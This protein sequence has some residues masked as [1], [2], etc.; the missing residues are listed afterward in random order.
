MRDVLP[1]PFYDN[2]LLFSVAIT[3]LLS[4]CLSLSHTNYARSLLILFVTHVLSLYGKEMI[5]YNLH[6]LV[7]LSDETNHFG[8]LDKVSS[9]PFES[10]LGQ[11]RKLLR[12]ANFP[13]QQI[14]RCISEKKDFI[15]KSIVYRLL[16]KEHIHGSLVKNIKLTGHQYEE[17]STE[18]FCIKISSRNNGLDS[19]LG[20]KTGEL[21]IV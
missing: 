21:V 6:G 12:N 10:C 4:P 18:Q 11:Q 5:T 9:F 7:Q 8:P 2:F 19:C 14:I 3:I 1:V 16:K 20:L 17:I 15:C 13:L